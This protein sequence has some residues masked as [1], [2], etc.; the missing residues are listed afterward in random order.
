MKYIFSLLI[1]LSVVSSVP[2]AQE[3]VPDP[4][5]PVARIGNEVITV[6]E[7]RRRYEM[8]V[9][10]GK[11]RRGYEYT[12]KLRFLY[13][14]VAERLLA[15]EAR[16][17]GFEFSEEMQNHIDRLERMHVRDRLYRD[18]VDR[19]LEEVKPELYI[20]IRHAYTSM[21]VD[22]LHSESDSSIQ[23]A[24]QAV[25]NGVPFDGIAEND[26][27]LTL[28][29]GYDVE[30]SQA[31]PDLA[32]ALD[33]LAVDQISSPVS[34]PAGWYI[35]QLRSKRVDDPAIGNDFNLELRQY[36]EHLMRH[37]YEVRNAEF[38][39]GLLEEYSLAVDGVLFQMIADGLEAILE[40]QYGDNLLRY[41]E[42]HL[43]RDN[44][45]TLRDMMRG[46][47]DEEFMSIRGEAWSVRKIIDGLYGRKLEF[48]GS[49]DMT[50]NRRIR[51]M[52]NDYIFDFIITRKAYDAGL[53]R[54]EQVVRDMDRWRNHILAESFKRTLAADATVSDDEVYNYYEDN[55]D[56]FNNPVEVN[57]REILVGTRFEAEQIM[58]RLSVGDDFAELA[59]RYSRRLWAARQGGEFGYFPS[60]KYGEIGRI[61]AMLEPGQRF[62]PFLID[63]GYT[64]F[65]LIDKREVELPGVQPFEDVEESIEGR[66]L[67]RKQRELINEVVKELAGRYIVDIDN[68]LLAAVEVSPLQVLVVRYFG[69]GGMYPA[70]PM[71][72]QI[73][74]WSEEWI[75]DHNLAL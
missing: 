47:L 50:L 51:N 49:D 59:R 52:V 26:D 69:F 22:F 6:D 58:Q 18:E 56:E 74:Q 36:E 64:I 37:S 61:A 32:V 24:W 44:V 62:G 40:E 5:V 20:T 66:L 75:I 28:V 30:L 29:T 14:M 53:D 15:M 13:G 57:I 71:L 45:E 65:E 2:F 31:H 68:E 19:L 55:R 67:Q 38:L 34:T 27:N 70:V 72:D 8:T 11:H 60:T 43:L 17:R 1:G 73:L 9:W 4:F 23:H 63:E 21:T 35:V 7:F 42:I 10:P 54:H 39:N 48:A 25:R 16:N 12:T 33:T 3:D 46:R 41:E